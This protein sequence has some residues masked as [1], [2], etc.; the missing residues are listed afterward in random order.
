MTDYVF[1]VSVDIEADAAYLRM[2]ANPVASTREV[3]DDVMV[4]LDEFGMVVGVE[5]LSVQ[6]EIPFQRLLDEFHVPSM[7]VEKLRALRPSVGA[8]LT[9]DVEGTTSDSNT[10]VRQ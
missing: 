2:S 5:M 3:T 1:Q 10:L 9:W 6:A 4:D 7:L 8:H